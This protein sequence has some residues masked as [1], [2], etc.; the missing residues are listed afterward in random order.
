MKQT[1]VLRRGC[2]RGFRGVPR[3]LAMVGLCL[4]ALA[5]LAGCAASTRAVTGQQPDWRSWPLD[6]KIGQML[7]IGFPGETIT[8]DSPIAVAIRRYG[9]AGVVLFDN[10]ADLGIT[11]RN[12]SSAP[13][14]KELTVALRAVPAETPI[15]IAVDEEGGIVTRLKER[16]GFPPT[17]SASYLGEKNDLNLTR[18]S[19]D[20]VADTLAEYGINLNLAP[21]VDLNVNPDNPVIAFK[22]RSFSADP[23][24]VVA[25]AAEVIGSHHRRNIVTCLKHF[26]GHGSS[27]DD[28]H[29]GFVDVSTTWSER[30]LLPYRQLIDRGQVDMIM[31]AHTFNGALDPDDPATLSKS[32]LDGILRERL[33]FDGVVASDDLYMGAIARHY[34]LETALEKAINAGVDLVLLANDKENSEDM[35]PRTIALVRSMVERGKISRERIDQACGRIMR[36][37]GTYLFK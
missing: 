3:G 2:S 25:H 18:T 6:R 22:Q 31:T 34:N 14:L 20:R 29:L 32:T 23:D 33:G 15:F 16:Y 8:P 19:S 35:A 36:L 27:R 12:I 4:L 37:K 5:M 21:V 28:S 1:Y 7:M 24:L 17:L 10:N 30:E 11:D 26:P 9:I 13:Q